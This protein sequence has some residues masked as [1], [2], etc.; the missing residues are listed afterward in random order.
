MPWA[1][2]EMVWPYEGPVPGRGC[3]E[4]ALSSFPF[5]P[6][7]GNLKTMHKTKHTIVPREGGDTGILEMPGLKPIAKLWCFLPSTYEGLL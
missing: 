3:I 1:C 4:H 6:Q 7:E 5:L 2:Q